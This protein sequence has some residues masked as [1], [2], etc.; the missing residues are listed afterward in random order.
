DL[1]TGYGLH[2][3]EEWGSFPVLLMFCLMFIGGCAGSTTCSIKVFRYQ[4]LYQLLKAQLYKLI[5]P[6]GVFL[7]MYNGRSMDKEIPLSVAGFVFLFFMTYLVMAMLLFLCG[8]DPVTALS[9]AATALCNVGPGLGQEIG[10]A[11]NFASLP[12][13]AK[14]VLAGGMMLGRLE[15]FTFF[16]LILP[17]FWKRA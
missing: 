12:D 1:G 10:P 13:S 4:V 11:T 9:G 2:D 6:R 16:V 14:W 15:L 3:F 7:T 17:D 8:L 5:H